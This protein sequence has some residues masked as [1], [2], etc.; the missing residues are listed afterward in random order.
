[1]LEWLVVWFLL[2]FQR[3][4]RNVHLSLESKNACH[5]VPVDFDYIP[6][7]YDAM[8]MYAGS[9]LVLVAVGFAVITTLVIL[10]VWQSGIYCTCIKRSASGG[11]YVTY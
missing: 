7:G 5:E 2:Q 4:S 11:Y 8:L 1:M 6:H 3:Q 10:P 9:V